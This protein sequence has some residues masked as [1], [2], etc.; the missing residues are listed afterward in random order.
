MGLYRYKKMNFSFSHKKNGRNLNSMGK[1]IIVIMRVE[2]VFSAWRNLWCKIYRQLPSI[3]KCT[4][5]YFFPPC[6]SIEMLVA[7][8]RSN[9][10]LK[11]HVKFPSNHP[12]YAAWKEGVV[13][14]FILCYRNKSVLA[15]TST[16]APTIT[17]PS[18]S[19]VPSP[20]RH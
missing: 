11:S 7:L 8:A 17:H 2:N 1:Y 3:S 4:Q 15:F 12:W 19:C 10:N 16:F 14:S 9:N 6:S 13:K 5:K 20:C 18:L